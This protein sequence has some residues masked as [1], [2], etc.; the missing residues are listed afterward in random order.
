M[1]SY[2]KSGIHTVVTGID[3]VQLVAMSAMLAYQGPMQ[4]VNKYLH[5]LCAMPDNQSAI[6]LHAG[7]GELN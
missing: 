7:H 3:P 6:T 5:R 2:G 1:Q 4:C